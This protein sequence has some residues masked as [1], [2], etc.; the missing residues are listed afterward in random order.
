[1]IKTMTSRRSQVLSWIE[2]GSISPDSIPKAL[3]VT[4][5]TPGPGR[6][7]RFL[8]QLFLALGAVS[9]ACAVV[10]FFA[11]NWAELGRFARFVLVQ[12]LVLAAVVLY[13]R[14]GTDSL[15][16]K[17]SLLVA[18]L[19]LGATLALYGQTYQTGAD[20]WQLFATWALLMLPWA[21]VGRMPAIWLLFLALLNLSLYQYY[22][23][24]FGLLG[25]VFSTRDDLPWMLFTLNTLAW[26]I[27]ELAGRKFKWL[28]GIQN[29][30]WAVRLI[31]LA[32]GFAI[33]SLVLRAVFDPES[34]A[35]LTWLVYLAWLAALYF[36]YRRKLPDL[37]MLAGAC[38]SLII[39]ITSVFGELV[40]RSNDAAGSL[41]FL[42]FLVIAQTAAVAYWLKRVNAEHSS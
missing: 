18:T 27:W 5:I 19:L 14:L 25:I 41:L 28:T 35:A 9:L 10:F 23:T 36:V 16:A 34:P 12:S 7:R 3:S 4:G 39:C 37:F 38:L 30:R 40:L 15:A 13:W 2:D 24:F 1:M 20:P 42:S 33:T 32:S 21:L 22:E 26:V 8:D 11:Y 17:L 6:W 29:S 31:A